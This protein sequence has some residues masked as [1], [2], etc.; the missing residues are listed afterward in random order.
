MNGIKMSDCKF[1]VDK[2]KRTI[3]CVIPSVIVNNG[4]QSYTKNMVFDFIDDNFDFNHCFLWNDFH[5][6]FLYFQR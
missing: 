4:K 3:V 5:R 2:E 6:N 1:Y